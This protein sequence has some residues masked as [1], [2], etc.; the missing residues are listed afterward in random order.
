MAVVIA[1]LVIVIVGAAAFVTKAVWFKPTGELRRKSAQLRHERADSTK[2]QEII[3]RDRHQ[4]RV[5]SR[6]HGA[7]PRPVR[8]GDWREIRVI[9][10]PLSLRCTSF[11]RPGSPLP[12]PKPMLHLVIAACFLSILLNT[13]STAQS[14]PATPAPAGIAWLIFVDDLHIDFR[15]TGRIRE[16]L[17]FMSGKLMRDGDVVVMRAS[18][19]SPV[20]T[21]ATSDRATIDA[22]IRRVSGAGLQ[23]REISE[24]AKDQTGEIDLRLALTFS[25]AATLLDTVPQRRRAML[26]ISNGYDSERGRTLASLFSRAAQQAQVTV[27]A[28]N[29]SGL[30]DVAPMKDP[31]V[32]ADLWKQMIASRRQSLRAIAEPTGGSAFLDDVYAAP[33][34][35]R[36]RESVAK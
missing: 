29:A 5:N 16:F 30:L 17:Q 33:T 25:S 27:F 24:L 13:G 4:S 32:D 8:P 1:V 2:W 14:R 15:N 22:A 11:T 3:R 6:L 23:P 28:V 19:P 31:R 10:D 35:S 21:D 20:T 36:I 26:Y 18:G 34:M 9:P 7:R 12:R